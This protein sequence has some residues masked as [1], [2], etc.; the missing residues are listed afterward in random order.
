MAEYPAVDAHTEDIGGFG[1]K[2]LNRTEGDPFVPCRQEQRSQVPSL[3]FYVWKK[4]GAED[5]WEGNN[6]FPVAFFGNKEG[7]AFQVN[8]GDIYVKD[9]RYA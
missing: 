9:G 8:I 4:K 2:V 1:K 6:P 7:A 5:L 3:C